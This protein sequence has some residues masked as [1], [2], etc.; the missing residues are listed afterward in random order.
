MNKVIQL[1]LKLI[2][3]SFVLI[4]DKKKASGKKQALFFVVLIVLMAP[5]I[6]GFSY[7]T[8]EI[9]Q[10]LIPL[11]QETV[12]LSL[13]LQLGFTIIIF[14]S[15][16]MIPAYMFY[17]KDIE[18][19]LPLPLSHSQLFLTKLLQVHIYQIG[20]LILII[21]P[22]LAGYILAS[23]FNWVLL[24]FLFSSWIN[25]MV[26]MIMVS[27]VL[28]AM[29]SV[30]PWLKNKDRVTL[31]MSILALAAA[32][33]INYN[34]G[35][36]D[37]SNPEFLALSLIQGNQSLTEGFFSYFPHLNMSVSLMI[38]FSWL[39]LVLYLLSS[40]IFMGL[41]IKLFAS[42]LIN[43]MATFQGGPTSKK[44][45]LKSLREHKIRSTLFVFTLKELKNLFRTPIYF[46]NNVLIVLLLPLIMGVSFFQIRDEFS[47]MML[48]STLATNPMFLVLFASAL[49]AA[50]SMIN[51]V[52]PTS[53]SREGENKYH[54]LLY[55]IDLT[56][57]L[58]AKL[59]SGIII[60]SFAVL[61][62]L[63]IIII[64]NHIYFELEL[65]WVIYS[66]LCALIMMVFINLFGLVIDVYHPKLVWENE[67]AAVKQ[68]I[69]F[70][71]TFFTSTAI[72]AFLTYSLFNLQTYASL[73]FFGVHG[74][75]M[76][77]IY[78]LHRIITSKSHDLLIEH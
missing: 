58:Y 65:I 51:L 12:V 54:M 70:L 74:L 1:S 49:S 5:N 19:L 9:T 16:F 2:K 36:L 59:L 67:Q 72:I 50:F 64:G 56:I 29:M 62:I 22:P 25:A 44:M 61:P 26:T 71:F 30:S 11:S 31:F 17:A 6:I 18:K 34:I 53:I 78:G 42:T 23:G 43:I 33:F 13:L 7:I 47:M 68:N 41:V 27:I 69:N 8:K 55:P 32:L 45:S 73:I 63:I 77:V 15:V 76:V 4:D 52:T 39:D 48:T 3:T 57:Q 21:L 28:V 38:H 10:F 20:F 40:F 60:S 14:S 37:L 75:L 35:G 24:S 46:F 66:I